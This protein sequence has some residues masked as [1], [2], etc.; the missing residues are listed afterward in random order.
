MGRMALKDVP[1]LNRACLQF[2]FIPDDFVVAASATFPNG[3]GEAPI[4][5]F[6]DHPVAHIPQPIELPF[7]TK[8]GYPADLSRNLH[9]GL[10]QIV[11]ANKHHSLTS[12]KTRSVPQRQHVG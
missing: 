9:H 12:R 7:S 3:K 4:A 5:F 2:V 1:A 11:H 8:G 10:A 6:T